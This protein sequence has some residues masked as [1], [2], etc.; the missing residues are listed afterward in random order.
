MTYY[1]TEMNT[2]KL[3]NC[4]LK[5]ILHEH[6]E[7]L[8]VN[9]V[10]SKIVAMMYNNN[11]DYYY[12]DTIASSV[13]VPIK[14]VDNIYL[15]NQSKYYNDSLVQLLEKTGYSGDLKQVTLLESNINKILQT[16]KKIN[17]KKNRFKN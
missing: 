6:L 7:P 1:L 12:S 8:L 2:I 14:F 9:G 11:I 16:K 3:E 10:T 13:N 17:T 4:L 15:H 5:F